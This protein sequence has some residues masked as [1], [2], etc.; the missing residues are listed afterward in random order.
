MPIMNDKPGFSNFGLS[1]LSSAVMTM[2][3]FDFKE[4]FLDEANHDYETFYWLRLSLLIAFLTIMPVILMNLLLAL[5]IGDTNS[6]MKQAK[7]NKHIQTAKILIDLER[8][9]YAMLWCSRSR[10]VPAL[11]ELPNKRVHISRQMWEYLCYGPDFTS[12]EDKNR[13]RDKAKTNENVEERLDTIVDIMKEMHEQIVAI[14]QKLNEKESDK[15]KAHQLTRTRRNDWIESGGRMVSSEESSIPYQ[16]KVAISVLAGT[17]RKLDQG[18]ENDS[19][20]MDSGEDFFPKEQDVEDD[21]NRE[22][23]ENDPEFIEL[24]EL[25]TKTPTED[26]TFFD[27]GDDDDDQEGRHIFA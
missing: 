1:M 3:E 22:K 13:K 21:E 25:H 18:G 5:A 10:M 9:R 23:K 8:K 27:D 12:D 16:A 14:Q 26:Y 20:R 24:R 11:E 4:T 15:K 2:G 17:S 6:I 19:L 7:L